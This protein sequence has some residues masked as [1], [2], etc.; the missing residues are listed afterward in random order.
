M[1]QISESARQEDPVSE[2]TEEC[3]F[4]S[5]TDQPSIPVAMTTG[6]PNPTTVQT[7][8]PIIM[9]TPPSPNPNPNPETADDLMREMQEMMHLQS[10]Q[11][12]QMLQVVQVTQAPP[13]PA[14]VL[15]QPSMYKKI[16]PMLPKYDG[17]TDADDHMDLFESIANMEARK[18]RSSM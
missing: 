16:N 15:Q 14:I 3:Y 9:A 18:E 8:S 13:A 17:K 12:T 7:P 6:S 5:V 10:Q 4:E 11:F 1:E 2:E